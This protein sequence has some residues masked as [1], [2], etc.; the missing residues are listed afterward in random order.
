MVGGRTQRR[1]LLAH[2]VAYVLA[3]GPI[4][5]GLMVLHACDNRAC[6]RP[7]HLTIGDQRENVRAMIERGRRGDIWAARRAP[8]ATP[9]ERPLTASARHREWSRAV[10]V[11]D[12]STCQTCGRTGRVHA[13]HLIPW[14][15]RPDLVYDADN[16]V[17]L[18]S[19]CHSRAHVERG[20]VVALSR[21]VR[22]CEVCGAEFA[23]PRYRPRRACSSKC[24][25]VLAGR[26]QP[27][28][29]VDVP[30][31][32][33]GAPVSCVASR[34]G[35]RVYC[36]RA[37][38]RVVEERTCRICGRTFRPIAQQVRRGQGRCCSKACLGQDNRGANNPNYRH[39][40][41]INSH[42]S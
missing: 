5:E 22:R 1:T 40:Q 7:E 19:P 37:C 9:A 17:T 16:G 41:R 4:A 33:C 6:V 10:K 26:M 8:D 39:G 2:R 38:R 35:E 15:E 23:A 30:C 42:L 36:N 18:C 21:E 28:R 32:R 27:K 14:R 20:D 29:R 3:H 34:V 24:G 25:Y 31:A 12:G 13:H 11:R